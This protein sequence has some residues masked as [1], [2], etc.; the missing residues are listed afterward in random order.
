MTIQ[1]NLKKVQEA[2]P[3]P[4]AKVGFLF[5][6]EQLHQMPHS[7]PVLNALCAADPDIETHAFVLGET[8][9]QYL[10][11]Q[12]S[13]TA[14]A[15]TRIHVMYA[16]LYARMLHLL[17]GKAVPFDRVGTLLRYRDLLAGMDLLV[18]P[19]TTS[20]LLK[21][22]LGCHDL[23]LVYTQHG[24]GDRAVGFKPVIRHFDHVLIAGSKIRDRML[25]AGLVRPGGFSEVGYPKFDG[26]ALAS[27]PRLF[28]DDRPTVL[29]NPHFHPGLSSWFDEGLKIL[30]FFARQDRYNLIVAPHVMLFARHVHAAP[31]PWRMRLRRAIP[32]RFFNHDHILVDTGSTAS[33]DMTYTRAADIYIGDVSSQVYEF[34]H[35]P[36]PCVFLNSHRHAWQQ[37]PN[38]AHWHLGA[39]AE[40]AADLAPLLADTSW[41]AGFAERQAQAFTATFGPHP[42]GGAR[43]AARVIRTLAHACAGQTRDEVKSCMSF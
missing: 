2:D 5:N 7:V 34:I 1:G 38:Y 37:D 19:E 21:S 43:R 6:H 22:R 10:I 16:P 39:V 28:G 9:A 13:P 3:V 20:T 4:R 26:I 30:D 40:S 17:C 29:Y 35:E 24:A 36:R 33:V 27:R 42:T 32:E 41:H 15:R 18:A 11:H 8:R 25:D 12:L 23:T 31:G 14:L